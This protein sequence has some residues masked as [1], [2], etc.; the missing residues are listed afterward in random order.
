MVFSQ[1]QSTD[2]LAGLVWKAMLLP[3]QSSC[4]RIKIAFQQVRIGSGLNVDRCALC[5]LSV[6][7]VYSS[8]RDQMANTLCTYFEIPKRSL[9]VLPVLPQPDNLSAWIDRLVDFL[10]FVRCRSTSIFV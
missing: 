5:L 10:V 9:C 6:D 2:V 3:S 8:E 1:L 7:D 4:F